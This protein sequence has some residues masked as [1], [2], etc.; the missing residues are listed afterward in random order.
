MDFIL[1]N[2]KKCCGDKSEEYGEW[3]DLILESLVCQK[4][5][6]LL[7]QVEVSRCHAGGTSLLCPET[8]VLFEELFESNETIF[9]HNIPYSPSHL[10]EQ[11]LPVEECDQHCFVFCFFYS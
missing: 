7:L 3:G 9:P 5:A 10:M 4:T 2:K 11:I 1:G 8:G 6:L